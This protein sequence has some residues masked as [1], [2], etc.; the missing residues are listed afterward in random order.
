MLSRESGAFKALYSNVTRA[1]HV[2]C[3]WGSRGELP[4]GLA[5]AVEGTLRR[6]GAHVVGDKVK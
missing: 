5:R 2:Y 1:L 4:E 6:A 3:L